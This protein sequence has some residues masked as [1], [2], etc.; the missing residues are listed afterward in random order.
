MAQ[1][2]QL[3]PFHELRHVQVQPASVLPTTEVAWLLQL[4]TA[5]H[6][7]KQAGYVPSCVE[8]QAAQF[9]AASYATGHV[10]QLV[11]V[12]WLLHVHTQSGRLPETAVARLL[13]SSGL[14]QMR[15][16]AG[17]TPLYPGAQL[18]Q[19]AP[20][21]NCTGQ[22]PHAGPVQELRHWQVQPVLLF[23]ATPLAWPEQF[24][25]TV[26]VR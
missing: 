18:A 16:Q 2:A 22:D 19:S 15:V 26:Q 23:P 7:R 21:L 3:L 8:A 14:V 17:Y 11:F 25:E 13:Q 5:V 6:L 24:A 10:W 20:E 4:A 12:H 9:W 1:V